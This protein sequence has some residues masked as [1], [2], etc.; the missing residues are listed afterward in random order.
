MEFK[1]IPSDRFNDVIVHLRKSFFCDEPLNKAV[2]LC[3]IGE[4][5]LELEHQTLSALQDG[6]SIMAVTSDDQ[7]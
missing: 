6:L 1:V 3:K 7:V 5:H 4:G 2:Q